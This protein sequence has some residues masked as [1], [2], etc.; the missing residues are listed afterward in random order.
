MGGLSMSQ[1][2]SDKPTCRSSACLQGM[3][4]RQLASTLSLWLLAGSI[5]SGACIG[6]QQMVGAASAQ[7]IGH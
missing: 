2:D 4:R 1:G 3:Y 7:L 5:A 6:P